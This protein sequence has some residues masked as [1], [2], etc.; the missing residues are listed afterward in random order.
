VNVRGVDEAR[1]IPGVSEVT[2]R[3]KRGD[4]IHTFPEQDRYIGFILARGLSPADVECTL[5]QAAAKLEFEVEL[6]Q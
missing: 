1:L 3:A 4:I 6:V 5:N 2:I